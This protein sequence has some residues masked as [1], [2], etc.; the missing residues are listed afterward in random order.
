MSI[1]FCNWLKVSYTDNTSTNCSD[2]SIFSSEL[3]SVKVNTK[4]GWWWEGRREEGLRDG[5]TEGG[6]WGKERGSEPEICG[7]LLG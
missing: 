6:R 4:T 3:N 2:W 7:F 1:H 5:G